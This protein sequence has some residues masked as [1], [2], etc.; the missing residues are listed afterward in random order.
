ML[1]C[2]TQSALARRTACVLASGSLVAPQ[3]C[4]SC[5]ASDGF[6]SRRRTRRIRDHVLD[7]PAVV[8]MRGLQSI[9][10]IEGARIRR[11][12]N[13]WS[14]PHG[15]GRIENAPR[16][17][18]GTRGGDSWFRLPASQ[19]VNRGD[20]IW[21]VGTVPDA[22]HVAWARNAGLLFA[23][24]E[25]EPPLRAL[26]AQ[27]QYA[28]HVEREIGLLVPVFRKAGMKI[29]F[30]GLPVVGLASGSL[31]PQ[32]REALAKAVRV[33]LLR[34]AE[35]ERIGIDSR[36]VAARPDAWIDDLALWLEDPPKRVRRDLAFARRAASHL[37]V[38]TE[39]ID[40]DCCHSLYRDT[41]VRHGGAV[42][43]NVNYFREL[44]D[45]ACRDDRIRFFAAIDQQHVLQAFA[46]VAVDGAAGYYLHAASSATVRKSGIGDLMLEALFGHA[47]GA[48]CNRFALM[49]SPWQQVGLLA[50]KRKWSTRQGVTV[51]WDDGVG[52]L[53]AILK[54]ATSWRARGDRR[55]A[56]IWID[57]PQGGAGEAG[58]SA[59]SGVD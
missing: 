58:R 53:G 54:R 7:P 31:S 32:D 26:G 49:A 44:H 19:T 43:Y 11:A 15:F 34:T 18:S 16:A 29:G 22:E 24:P 52:P 3:V 48:G 1:L 37:R 12:C 55:A 36:A 59:D 40:P 5:N 45:L 4:S 23:S 20:R 10:C 2:G 21:C 35:G 46:T 8:S 6:A 42:R 13:A 38:T 28:W 57:H 27:V 17:F 33:D 56:Q 47:S 51:T 14:I 9:Q 30:A 41:V 25:W 39:G 50:F